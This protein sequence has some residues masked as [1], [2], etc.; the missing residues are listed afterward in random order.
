MK[1]SSNELNSKLKMAEEKVKEVED[2]TIDI[3][4]SEK[5]EKDWR[6]NFWYLRSSMNYLNGISTKKT[7]PGHTTIKLLE[8]KDQERILKA[9]KREK[10]ITYGGT[11]IHM[12][13]FS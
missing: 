8:V 5:E 4:H 9:V 6:T 3:I 2:R 12:K 10:Y 7:I 13:T 11:M 1:T